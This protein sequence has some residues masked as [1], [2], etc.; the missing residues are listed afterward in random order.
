MNDCYKR[1][2]QLKNQIRKCEQEI[3]MLEIEM[4]NDGMDNAAK[5][6][7][8][9]VEINGTA[10]EEKFYQIAKAKNLNLKRQYRINIVRKKDGYI[11]RFYFADFCDVK[12]KLIFEVDGEYH[13]TEEQHKKDFKRT[14][15]L[16][17]MGY[18][19]FRISNSQIF[20]GKTTQFL[21]DCYKKI[22]I[23]IC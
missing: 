19:V 5:G 9:K 8:T 4:H 7:Q 14:K 2:Q 20:R 11:T 23:D 21:A 17:R 1:I 22:N 16:E 18:K 15:D 10:A 12:N 3:K 6:L 13:F